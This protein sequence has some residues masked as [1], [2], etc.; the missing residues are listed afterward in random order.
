MILDSLLWFEHLKSL[1]SKLS[2]T[3]GLRRNIKVSFLEKS[4]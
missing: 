1:L 2:K 3:I 4:Y